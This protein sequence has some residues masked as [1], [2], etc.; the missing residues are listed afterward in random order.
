LEAE[1]MR[2]AG[3]EITDVA[4]CY[5]MTLNAITSIASEVAHKYHDPPYMPSHL[6]ILLR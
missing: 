1:N 5:R 3:L 2:L 6:R 4:I